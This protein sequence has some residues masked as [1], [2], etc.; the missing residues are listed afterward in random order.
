MLPREEW[1]DLARKLDWDLGP[2][3]EETA[4]GAALFDAS[5][6]ETVGK[7]GSSI[8]SVPTSSSAKERERETFPEVASGSPWLPREAWSGWEEPYRTGFAEYV[9]NQAAKEAAV[10]AVRAAVGRADD[11]AAL[12]RPWRSALKL[13]GATLPL[14]ELAA[15]VGNLRAARFGRDAAWRSTALLGALDE[16]RHT[17]IPLRVLHELVRHDPQFDWVHRFYHSNDWVA[18]A[19]RHFVDEMLLGSSALE[20]AVATNFVFETG[21]TNL[22]FVGLAALARGAGDRMF[23]K[24]VTSIQTDEAR[25]A[26][27]GPAVLETL[28]RHDRA[29]AQYL[30]DK[31]F[32]RS[33]HLF[34]VVT[35]FSM[36]YLT[37]LERREAS[38]KEFMHEWVIDQYLR[39]VEE[40]GLERPWYW[41]RFL[42]SVEHYHH[43][44]YASAYTYRFTVWF[45]V[46]LPGPDERAWLARKYPASWPAIEPVWERVTERWRAADPGN[47]VAVHGTAIVGFCNLC[48]LVLC[49]GTPAHNAARTLVHEGRKYVFCSEPCQW[50]FEQEPERYAGHRD[51][52]ARVLAGEAPANLVA[53]LRRY[54]GL[55]QETW[56]KDAEGGRYAWLRGAAPSRA[57]RPAPAPTAGL[58]TA[59]GRIPL[60]DETASSSLDAADGSAAKGS[61]APDRAA[62]GGAFEA[63]DRSASSGFDAAN[64][65]VPGGSRATDR[66]A[67]GAFAATNRSASD[68]L[69]V[70]GANGSATESSTGR[71]A[72]GAF[73]ATDRSA[74][75]GLDAAGGT[76]NGL[77]GAAAGAV[78]EEG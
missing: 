31:W 3:A 75:S 19:A 76:A 35:G 59:S 25:H 7:M 60:A 29:R 2:A 50:I 30:L 63:T 37:P 11:L 6:G 71:S 33:F 20:L 32:W 24:M 42:A 72:R 49:E 18:I 10:E 41:D 28:V 69:D 62:G 78:E 48:Q 57:A 15:T 14:A 74:N 58:A 34:A 46:V 68:R 45:D 21:F 53:M 51:I 77:F 8:G 39:N 65:S 17:Q 55:T 16:L 22:Q 70:D 61:R 73:A 43:M 47:E 26:Q 4:E 56:G 54:F 1:I 40:M 12:P 13:H 27:I 67:G 9:A 23:E 64:G 66:S 52:V 38:F 5:R 36:D 44:V